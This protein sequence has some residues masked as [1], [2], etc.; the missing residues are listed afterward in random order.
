MVVKQGGGHDIGD[1]DS[2]LFVMSVAVALVRD[3]ICTSESL[4]FIVADCVSFRC[5]HS[6]P[7]GR[8]A[9]TDLLNNPLGLHFKS[10]AIELSTS[11][12]EIVLRNPLHMCKCDA[13]NLEEQSSD[14]ESLPHTMPFCAEF[15]TWRCM[16]KF[17]WTMK[18]R[19]Q[20]HQ[21]IRSCCKSQW[22]DPV[23]MFF[24]TGVFVTFF[25]GALQ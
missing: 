1:C 4:V 5:A 21:L 9:P 16:L 3:M 18:E 7:N 12:E 8:C 17:T 10:H 24:Q 2:I 22:R 20:T 13:R 25:E 11:C 14:W 23:I 19:N 15:P 6:L